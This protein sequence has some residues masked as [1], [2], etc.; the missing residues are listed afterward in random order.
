[1]IRFIKDKLRWFLYKGLYKPGHF[2]SPVPDLQYVTSSA[3][4]IFGKDDMV[5]ININAERQNEFLLKM[6][7]LR[8]DFKWPKH[9]TAGYRYHCAN[10]YF[11]APDAFSL[12]S[13]MMIVKP[14]RIIEIG[15]GFSSAVMMDTNERFLDNTTTIDFIDPYPERLNS[16]VTDTDRSTG[17]YNFHTNFIQ[18]V[19]IS[20]FGE[21][22]EN[23]MLF[24]DSSHVSKV[25]SDLNHILFQIIP[26][27]KKGVF[28]HFHDIFYP[29]EYPRDWVEKG[30]YWNEVYLIRAF[31]MYN[32]HFEIIFFNNYHVN[33]QY[34]GLEEPY[35]GGSLWL[36]KTL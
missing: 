23:D 28:I 31:L 30:I 33:F 25:G 8:E 19:D 26:R 3:G 14:K 18:N 24:V 20:L 27:L 11:I 6:I 1:M 32:S 15:S 29:L 7:D 34:P 36:R 5:G 12:Y 21:L 2:Y 4:R 9:K 13:M 22:E 17:R 10:D 35:T 16:L